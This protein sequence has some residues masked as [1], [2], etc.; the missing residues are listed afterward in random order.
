MLRRF[1]TLALTAYLVLGPA[2]GAVRA[3]PEPVPAPAQVR[4]KTLAEVRYP[5]VIRVAIRESRPGG[6]PDPRGRITWVKTV[7]FDEYQ[8]DV[9]PN[10]WLPSWNLESLKAGAVAVKMFAWYHTLYPTVADGFR[11]EVDNSVNFQTYREG[12]RHQATNQAVTLVRRQAYVENDGVIA[13]TYYRAGRPRD[14]NWQYRNR[15]KM[16]QWGSHYWAERGQTYIQILQ[17]YYQGKILVPIP[18]L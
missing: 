2:A 15:N 11:Y 16:A 4:P 6:E 17:W 8:R 1:L 14:P 9:L 7:N 13:P 3:E 18:G 10:E 5:S 12:R